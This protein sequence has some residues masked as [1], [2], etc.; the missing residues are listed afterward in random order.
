MCDSWMISMPPTDPRKMPSQELVLSYTRT[1][2]LPLYRL[3]YD[4][5]KKYDHAIKHVEGRG[6]MNPPRP[7]EKK[8]QTAVDATASSSSNEEV[9][10]EPPVPPAG[11]K[12]E[13]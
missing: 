13:L 5:H 12:Q 3:Y 7:P 2:K 4:L 8:K 11:D 9:K 10:T 6:Q 1:K